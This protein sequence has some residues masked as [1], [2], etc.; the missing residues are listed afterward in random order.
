[1]FKLIL[2]KVIWGFAPICVTIAIMYLL[3]GYESGLFGMPEIC[4]IGQIPN[5]GAANIGHF[6]YIQTELSYEI[7]FSTT[8]ILLVQLSLIQLLRTY[9]GRSKPHQ[10]NHEKP[11]PYWQI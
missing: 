8:T 5:C 7:I 4:Q 3:L 6:G 10:T 1:M 2:D 11:I 9:L